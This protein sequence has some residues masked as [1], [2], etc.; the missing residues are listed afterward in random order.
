[1][2]KWHKILQLCEVGLALHVKMVMSV[3]Q[4]LGYMH[5]KTMRMSTQMIPK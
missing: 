3:K 2:I 1:M 5:A 4:S